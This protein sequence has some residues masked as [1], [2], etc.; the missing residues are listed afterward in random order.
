VCAVCMDREERN[1]LMEIGR[2]MEC[3]AIIRF[4]REHYRNGL[5]ITALERRVHRAGYG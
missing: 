5:L 4:V 3:E 2:E 1:Q